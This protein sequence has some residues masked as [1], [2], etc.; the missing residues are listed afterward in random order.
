MSKPLRSRMRM[1]KRFTTHMTTRSLSLCSL[2]IIRP[3]GCWQTMEVRRASYITLPSNNEAQ[4]RSTLSSKFT[5]SRI[6][7]N[8]SATYRHYYIT[9]NGRSI[10]TIDNQRSK[11]SCH[12]LFIVIQRYHWKT[13]F[14]QLEGSNIYLPFFY[15]VPNKLRSGSRARKPINRQKMLSSHVGHGQARAGLGYLRY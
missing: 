2:L 3:K 8:E 5:L 7:R 1:L 15:E 13:N 11:L 12:G 9:C 4:T 14:K 6:W 10:S